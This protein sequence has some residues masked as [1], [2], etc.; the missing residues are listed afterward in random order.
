MSRSQKNFR[1]RKLLN[2]VFNPEV[3]LHRADIQQLSM[4]QDRIPDLDQKE[5]E[6]P[7]I[8]EEQEEIWICPEGEQLQ[9]YEEYSQSAM[10]VEMVKAFTN[11]SA[12]LMRSLPGDGR[13][14]GKSFYPS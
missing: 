1:L 6:S 2:A 8:K 5:P 7:H 3:R 10:S 4:Q 14:S 12:N 13:R 11:S 9:V